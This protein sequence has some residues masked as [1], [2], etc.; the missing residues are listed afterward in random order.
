MSFYVSLCPINQPANRS[1]S[2]LL[3]KAITHKKLKTKQ[4]RHLTGLFL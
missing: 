4:P 3:Y 2:P 1:P